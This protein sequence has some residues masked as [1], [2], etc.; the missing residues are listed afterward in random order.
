MLLQPIEGSLVAINGSPISGPTELKSGDWIA[1]D[2]AIFNVRIGGAPDRALEKALSCPRPL[3][4]TAQSI[5]TLTIGRLIDNDLQI[6]SP[7]ISR[8]H[9]TLTLGE[10]TADITDLNSENGT[11]VNGNRVH[12]QV[13]VHDGDLIQFANFTYT[14]RDAKLHSLDLDGAIRIDVN[15]VT[16][17]VKDSATA[18]SRDL[19]TDISFTVLPGEFVGIFGTS[20]SGKSTLVDA[21]NGRRPPSSGEIRYNGSPLPQA[22]DRFRSTIG[23]VPQQDIVHRRITMRRALRYAARLRLPRDTSDGEIERCVNQVLKRVGLEDKIDLAIDTPAPLSGGQLKR[24][25]LAVELVANPSVLFLDEATTGLDAGTE[26]KIMQLF[27]EFA[28]DRKSV[29]CVTHSLENIDLCHFV[30]I[31]CG[32]RL[33]FFGPPAKALEPVIF[34][35]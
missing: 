22:L 6:G 10:N 7:I 17:T 19:L 11:F 1:L 4:A 16:K 25:S 8:R 32:G 21:L 28:A 30:V 5:R 34:T 23:Y 15:S 26:R 20:G 29:V 13:G 18:T 27:A 2:S 12:G 14:F 3:S 31:L 35:D 33:A 9:A 24:V